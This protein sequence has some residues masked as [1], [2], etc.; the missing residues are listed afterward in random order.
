MGQ[1]TKKDIERAQQEYARRTQNVLEKETSNEKV[2]LSL[3]QRLEK[4][5]NKYHNN[6][7]RS[8]EAMR[9]LRK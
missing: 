4:N 3:G 5:A 7:L 6:S 1:F 8:L 2:S 9:R